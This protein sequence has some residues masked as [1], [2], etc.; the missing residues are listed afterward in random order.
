MVSIQYLDRWG[1]AEYIDDMEGLCDRAGCQ[2][3]GPGIE[4][5]NVEGL[6]YEPILAVEYAEQYFH[7]CHCLAIPD[8]DTA[9]VTNATNPIDLGE[10]RVVN[11]PEDLKEQPLGSIQWV[12]TKL[13]LRAKQQAGRSRD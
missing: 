5:N 8:T 11:L 2:C 7:T 1:Q 10:G 13:A 4:C 9:N 12:H 6:F 3:V